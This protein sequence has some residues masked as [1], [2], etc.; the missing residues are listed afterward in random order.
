MTGWR[1]RLDRAMQ[2]AG[3]DCVMTFAP[4]YASYLAKAYS[5]IHR[6]L[7]ERPVV[8][9]LT[10][11]AEPT[12]IC[13][14]VEERFVREASS[15]SQVVCYASPADMASTANKVLADQGLA[16]AK[17]GL[18]YA[19]TPLATFHQLARGTEHAHFV[20]AHRQL[21][22]VVAKKSGEAIDGLS[23]AAEATAR[24]EAV[25]ITTGRSN[26]SEEAFAQLLRRALVDNG[27][28][29][30]AFLTLGGS[31]ARA[32]PQS[33]PSGRLLEPG[34]LVR[35]DT[36]GSFSGWLS[37]MARTVAV[38]MATGKQKSRYAL[39][40]EVLQKHTERIRAGADAAEL[41]RQVVADF[42]RA[43]VTYTAPHVGHGIGYGMHEWPILAPDADAV[44]EPDMVLC[45][46][47]I[48]GAGDGETYHLEQCVCV[49]DSAPQAL[50]HVSIPE[51]IPVLT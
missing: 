20:D 5:P 17:I 41:Y 40:W 19:T 21:A 6:L 2:S 37:D 18:D 34:E 39:A 3:L 38:T 28:E 22:W 11:K 29:D 24:A 27:A 15:G 9:V 47:V 35:F 33:P 32:T 10:L 7:P 14:A 46:E 12:V 51:S 16:R 45:S 8:L 1:E 48:F 36:G 26:L 44:L 13:A 42:G 43:G 30:I 50:H 4:E 49:T 31:A 25:A 23:Q